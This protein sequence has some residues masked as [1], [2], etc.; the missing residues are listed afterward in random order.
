MALTNAYKKSSLYQGTDDWLRHRNE[1]KF[2]LTDVGSFRN[3][4]P[5]RHQGIERKLFYLFEG[6][7]TFLL[8]GA[9][10]AK[11]E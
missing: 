4:F 11:V 1:S 10:C 6:V 5:C 7:T 8:K 2:G 9:F 3:S